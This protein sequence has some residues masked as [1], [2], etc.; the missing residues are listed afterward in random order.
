MPAI[1]EQLRVVRPE[2]IDELNH[3][4]NIEYIRW[5]QTAAVRHSDLQGWTTADYRRIGMGWVV[6]SH[7][8]EYLQ[9]AYSGDEV[10]IRTWVCDMKKVTSARRFEIIRQSDSKQLVQA[11]TNWAFIN[12]STGTLSRIPAEVSQ[13]FEILSDAPL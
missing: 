8:I 5:M 11:T 12:F 1:F 6:R 13:S 3:V 2:E 10:L 9:P 4:N 7:F